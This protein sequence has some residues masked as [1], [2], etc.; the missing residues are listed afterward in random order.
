MTPSRIDDEKLLN[1]IKSFGLTLRAFELNALAVYDERYNKTKIRTHSDR[2]YT[3][4]MDII[5]W[6]FMILYQI[7][8]SSQVIKSSEASLLV[9]NMVYTSCW[10]TQDLGS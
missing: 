7:F 1:N 2:V 3:T 6:D 4:T 9:I 5:F 10:M 8:F